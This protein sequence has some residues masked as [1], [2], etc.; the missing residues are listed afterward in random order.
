MKSYFEAIR[1]KWNIDLK[2]SQILSFYWLK[3]KK[4]HNRKNWNHKNTIE[5]NET[6]D[7]FPTRF[8]SGFHSILMPGG[9]LSFPLP[10]PS[11]SEAS[12]I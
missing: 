12:M 6:G 11:D 7:F 3:E 8:L 5:R 1:N 4:K 10:Q 2:K 9:G